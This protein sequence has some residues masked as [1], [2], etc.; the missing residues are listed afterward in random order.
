VRP[1]AG[2]FLACSSARQVASPPHRRVLC[3]SLA[4]VPVSSPCPI[5]SRVRCPEAVWPR[6]Q[7]NAL[8]PLTGISFENAPI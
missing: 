7:N 8:C 4:L 6:P 1:L 3:Y 5:R 2:S